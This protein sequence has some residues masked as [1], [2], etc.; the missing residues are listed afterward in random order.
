MTTQSMPGTL[1]N[2]LTRQRVVLAACVVAAALA[3]GS[4]DPAAGKTTTHPTLLPK[5][6]VLPTRDVFVGTSETLPTMLPSNEILYGCEPHETQ[7][8]L[9]ASPASTLTDW[10]MRCLRFDTMVVNVGA[11]RLELRYAGNGA[12][13]K[14]NAT[15]RLYR[16][17]DTF[18]DR[19]AGYFF[20]DAAHQHFHYA[21]FAWASLWQSNARGRRLGKAPLRT[22]RKDGFCLEDM[23]PY[24]NTADDARYKFPDACYPAKQPDGSITQVNGISPGNYDTYDETLPNQSIVINGVPDGYYLLQ[25]TVDPEHTLLVDSHSRMSTSQLIRLCGDA[26]DI[27]GVTHN[28][29]RG[30]PSPLSPPANPDGLLGQ[31]WRQ[32]C[33]SGW[34]PSTPVLGAGR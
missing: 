3:G 13:Q 25:I 34:C 27:V 16:R 28:C 1:A 17:D 7:A 24:T 21:N 5:L 4:V 31:H 15:Q 23:G 32:A 33:F 29:G 12:V 22:S 26:A 14:E 11:G 6:V 2:M 8:A 10:P 20:F 9:A 30:A 18:V 19:S